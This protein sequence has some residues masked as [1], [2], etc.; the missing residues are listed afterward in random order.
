LISFQ[1][2]AYQFFAL[3]LKRTSR[4]RRKMS[5]VVSVFAFDMGQSAFEFVGPKYSKL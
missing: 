1:A 5:A 2:G 3:A 4:L